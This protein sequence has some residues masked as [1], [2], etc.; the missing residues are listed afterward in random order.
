[1]TKTLIKPITNLF[2]KG[3]LRTFKRTAFN[4][5]LK[6]HYDR[7]GIDHNH[8][9]VVEYICKSD[10]HYL[11]NIEK[12]NRDLLRGNKIKTAVYL[13]AGDDAVEGLL[14]RYSNTEG[15]NNFILIDYRIDKYRCISVNDNYR[16]FTIPSEVVRSSKILEK[17]NVKIDILIDINC[18]INLGNGFF[19][20]T[21]VL[22]QSL[23]EP[24]CNPD[25]FIFIGSYAYQKCNAQYK[26]AR[27]YLRCFQY[28]NK[29]KITSNKLSDL[30]Y[31]INLPALTTYHW[32]THE[33]DITVFNTKIYYPE[34]IIEKEGITLHFV[35]GNIFNFK[36]QL[37]IMFL[38]Y[39]NL[40]MYR[41]FNHTII[42]AL[43]FRGV[44]KK[45]INRED[46]SK[47]NN[48]EEYNFMK[49][50]D[51][52]RFS[53]IYNLKSVG[54]VPLK[55]FD[56]VSYINNI[57][58]SKSKITDLY[59]FYFDDKDPHDIYRINHINELIN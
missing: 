26:P 40:F 33:I 46:I 30:G 38:Y 19:S 27:D 32:S 25:Q 57:C 34:L 10:K 42:N 24:L 29:K 11:S 4:S 48:V 36:N 14:K 45:C 5:T 37:D 58:N 47:G 39:R 43:D 22:V 1:M 44:Y 6:N 28:K 55:D 31:N 7:K 49:S 16:I 50:E 8:G 2:K 53:N 13:P 23:F 51:L 56:Y 52:V 59:F 35:K 17:C 15:I 21:S 54:F 12:L 18:G 3:I 9:R 41:Q 20:T